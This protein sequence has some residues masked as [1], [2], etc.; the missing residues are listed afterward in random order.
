MSSP[1]RRR[2]GGLLS[3]GSRCSCG[4]L[5]SPHGA[6]VPRG[7]GPAL[8]ETHQAQ[9]NPPGPARLLSGLCFVFLVC[10]Q[11]TE[12]TSRCAGQMMAS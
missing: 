5:L 11:I 12:H 6:P 4:L 1:G 9:G 8:K 2:A 3:C 10:F 7:P